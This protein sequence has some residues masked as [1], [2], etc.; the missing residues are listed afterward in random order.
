MDSNHLRHPYEECGLPVDLHRQM[1]TYLPSRP[2]INPAARDS[3]HRSIFRS[4]RCSC[5]CGLG[6]YNLLKCGA[7]GMAGFEPTSSGPPDQRA[8]AALHSGKHTIYNGRV[9]G[10]QSEWQD[11]N[12]RSPP[13][14]GGALVQAKLHS[15]SG[16]GIRTTRPSAYETDELT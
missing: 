14:E 13:P 3:L 12:L 10:H 15:G 2:A 7:V 6:S 8:A 11:S 9:P 5:G 1:S 4:P 16:G